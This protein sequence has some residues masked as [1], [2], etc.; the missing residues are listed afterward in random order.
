MLNSIFFWRE[1]C[2]YGR[3]LFFVGRIVSYFVYIIKIVDIF[4]LLYF[5]C[6]CHEKARK[7]DKKTQNW[8]YYYLKVIDD[9]YILIYS[10]IPSLCWKYSSQWLC[11]KIFIHFLL[12]KSAQVKLKEAEANK[13]ETKFL[14]MKAW[15]KSRIRQL[16]EELKKVQVLYSATS[17]FFLRDAYMKIQ[18]N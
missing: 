6:F 10:L 18:L 17:F 1:L 2:K 5:I 8:D 9:S 4:L 16:E 7:A 3:L 13:A 15:S 14:K 12:F 11:L